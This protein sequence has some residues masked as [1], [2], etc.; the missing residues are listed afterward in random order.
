MCISLRICEF[1]QNALFLRILRKTK[2]RRAVLNRAKNAQNEQN[3]VLARKTAQ[4][5]I[6]G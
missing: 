3:F 1:A 2:Q 5:A 4:N 6:N